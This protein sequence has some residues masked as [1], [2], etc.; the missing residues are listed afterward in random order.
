[1]NLGFPQFRRALTMLRR[2]VENGLH[3]RRARNKGGDTLSH[4]A[5]IRVLPR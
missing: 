2:N 4:E 3:L 5:S 1:M